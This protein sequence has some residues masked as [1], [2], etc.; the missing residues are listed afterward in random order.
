MGFIED[1]WLEILSITL[2]SIAMVVSL[3]SLYLKRLDIEKE[4]L[5][6]EIT[7]GP[8]DGTIR[9]D[10]EA[11]ENQDEIPVQLVNDTGIPQIVNEVW[12]Q[13]EQYPKDISEEQYTRFKAFMVALLA[14]ALRTLG[15]EGA[16]ERLREEMGK[17]MMGDRTIF[18]VA[19]MI[20]VINRLRQ[21][22]TRDVVVDQR[23]YETL[24]TTSSN[25]DDIQAVLSDP[26]NDWVVRKLVTPQIIEMLED[27]VRP[28]MSDSGY[29][30]YRSM[31]LEV[32]SGKIKDVDIH[33]MRFAQ[34]LYDRLD[35]IGGEFEF[36][37]RLRANVHKCDRMSE[38]EMFCLK[39][40]V[41]PVDLEDLIGSVEQDLQK[42]AEP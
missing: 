9:V 16:E 21:D 31:K 28:L 1:Y 10:R 36:L 25:L 40:V 37:C 29:P 3:Y 24:R 38:S 8:I 41:A 6:R 7:F 26:K 2:S 33:L 4:R 20:L 39:I 11:I 23:L 42:M 30:L 13:I 18:M 14:A 12:V 32:P 22:D 5:A 35:I 34:R 27:H 19:L 17:R 15:E